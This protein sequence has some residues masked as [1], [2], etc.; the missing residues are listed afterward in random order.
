MKLMLDYYFLNLKSSRRELPIRLNYQMVRFMPLCLVL[1]AALLLVW[2]TPSNS[3]SLI[4][5][6]SN[7][8]AAKSS[9]LKRGA[10]VK[11]LSGRSLLVQ[12]ISQQS[13]EKVL[14]HSLVE[15]DSRVFPAT[16]PSELSQTNNQLFWIHQN[17]SFPGADISTPLA[18]N[19][20]RGRGQVI[21]VLDSGISS[22]SKELTGQVWAN[23]YDS[24]DGIDND[25]NGIVDDAGGAGFYEGKSSANV[26]D[27]FG[28]GTEVSSLIAARANNGGIV[29]VAPEAKI[30]PVKILGDDGSGY[31][32]DLVQGINYAVAHG[33]KIINL[34]LVSDALSPSLA[35]LDAVAKAAAS[36]V[37][38]VAA[39][40]NKGQNIDL[41][42]VYPAALANNNILSVGASDNQDRRASFSNFGK[43]NVDLFAPGDMVPLVTKDN[44]VALGSGTSFAAPIAAAGAA[45][46]LSSNSNLSPQQLISLLKNNV[47]KVSSL[48]NISQSGGR[49][50]VARLFKTIPASAVAKIVSP[51]YPRQSL[52]RSKGRVTLVLSYPLPATYKVYLDN[53]L[54]KTVTNQ[55]RSTIRVKVK[56]GLHQLKVTTR[57][58]G[59]VARIFRVR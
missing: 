29:G 2:A 36:R 23:P 9:L 15:I 31:E 30:M 17:E 35:L 53:K 57:Q 42:P 48:Q 20:T 13:V 26:E 52:K 33:A 5:S 32:S 55:S 18:W 21:A 12:K 37:L 28:H 22:Q 59:S 6:T 47:D 10:R 40:G 24:K 43:N 27:V 49:L 19:F 3:Q 34:S 7:L 51:S 16:D 39:A 56:K 8:P 44:Q 25:N 50:S 54:I 1:S 58:S 45:L 14:P 38:I 11:Q 41:S 4:V 46:A